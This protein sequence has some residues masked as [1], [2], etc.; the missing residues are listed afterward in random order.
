ML[1]FLILF[2]LFITICEKKLSVEHILHFNRN[3]M[4]D[5]Y[6]QAIIRLYKE[7]N[8][9]HTTSEP[10]HVVRLFLCFLQPE[11][12]WFVKAETRSSV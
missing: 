10:L 4:F 5:F 8:V 9:Q 12:G 6:K 11:Y 7:I 3:Y 2:I 1:N